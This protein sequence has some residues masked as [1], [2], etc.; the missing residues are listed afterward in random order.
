MKNVD[1]FFFADIQI[2]IIDWAIK[3]FL[4]HQTR[5][6]SLK[7]FSV[8]NSSYVMNVLDFFLRTVQN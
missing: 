4:S 1:F 3:S 2:E 5:V 7:V 8:L 6:K